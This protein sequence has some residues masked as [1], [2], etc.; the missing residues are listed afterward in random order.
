M[1]SIK[2][3]TFPNFVRETTELLGPLFREHNFSGPT[4]T[5]DGRWLY[6]VR[7]DKPALSFQIHYNELHVELYVNIIIPKGPTTGYSLDYVI[8]RLG[9]ELPS[10]APHLPTSPKKSASDFYPDLAA[11]KRLLTECAID[12]LSGEIVLDHETLRFRWPRQP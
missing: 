11:Y 3:V 1:P 10:Y 2:E 12:I 9:G 5:R 8:R 7:F 4:A 6:Y